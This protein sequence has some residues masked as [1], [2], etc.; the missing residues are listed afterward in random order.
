MTPA[1]GTQDLC[2]RIED[3][4]PDL[5]WAVNEVELLPSAR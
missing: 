5:T 2:L 4:A 1:S 3:A